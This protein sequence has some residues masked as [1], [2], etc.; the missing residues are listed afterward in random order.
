MDIIRDTQP[1]KT[2]KKLVWSVVGVGL[3]AMTIFVP[4]LLPTAAPTVDG[5]TVWR[6]TVDFGTM[7][8]QVRGP[9]TLIPEQ[10]RWITAV[11][12]GRIEQ[13]LSLPGTEV[14]QGALI[15]RMSNPDVDM[16]LLQ[17]QQ[18]LSQARAALAQLRK[19][20]AD[21]QR[22]EREALGLSA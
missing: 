14:E 9:G 3:L 4:R 18:Q 6:D 13:I 17:A 16:Q 5:A 21:A 19:G 10:T 1:Q 11:T 8:R 22:A 15:M 20:I 2:R 7:I 12:A